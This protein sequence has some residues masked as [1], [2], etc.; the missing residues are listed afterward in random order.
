MF[1]IVQTKMDRFSPPSKRN[2]YSREKRQKKRI[3][4][5]FNVKTLRKYC[6]SFRLLLE[7]NLE[8]V[9]E[10][11]AVFSNLQNCLEVSGSLLSH[12]EKNV[13]VNLK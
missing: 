6:F 12:V 3:G 7:K 9:S 10:E 1:S 5:K 8:T 13:K 2:F 11:R 4:G